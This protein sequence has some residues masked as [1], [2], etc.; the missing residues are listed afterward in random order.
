MRKLFLSLFLL[1]GC[2]QDP[3]PLNA[4][5]A[6]SGKIKVASTTAMIDD[7][8]ARVGGEKIDHLTLI[9]GDI[10]P[11][12]Y[13]L[14]KGDAEKLSCAQIVFYN[15]LGLEHG[16][17]LRYY[18][19]NHP[20]AVALGNV[21]QKKHPEAIL[22]IKN[23]VDPHIWLDI[24]LW[25]EVVDPIV[26]ELSLLDPENR[27]YFMENGERLKEEMDKTHAAIVAKLQAVPQ[28][29]KYLVTSHDAFNYFTRR[30]LGEEE[31]CRAP[32]G[33]APDGQLS[34]AD[35]QA[36]IDHLHRYE[37]GVVFPESNVSR[38]ALKKIVSACKEKGIVV[39]IAQEPLYADTLGQNN[40]LKMMEQNV[41]VLVQ[42]WK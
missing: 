26:E 3:L 6:S 15:G 1:F 5:M 41:D 13:E 40:Y 36:I 33:L 4:W 27:A 12:S 37:I 8:V 42:E 32:E 38:D 18:L 20:K 17:S 16:A 19:E 7:L 10:D 23:Q 9:H 34:C 39:K 24:L 30:Y 29:R 35:I 31:R 25:K 28:S 22:I 14:V 11:H 21:V 2:S